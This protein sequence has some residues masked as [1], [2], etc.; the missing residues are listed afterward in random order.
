[1]TAQPGPRLVVPAYFHPAVRPQDWMTLA[2]WG[3]AVWFVVLNLADGPGPAHDP[4][5]DGPLAAIRAAGSAVACYVDTGFGR[6][7]VGDVAADLARCRDRYPADTAVFFDRVSATG[8]DLGHYA[9]L[10]ERARTVGMGTIVFNHGVHPDPRYARYA[11]L[12]GTFEGG[13]EQYRRLVVPRWARQ[14]DS[15]SVL[16][17]VHSVPQRRLAQARALVGQ[18]G[19]GAAFVTDAATGE[20]RGPNPWRRLPADRPW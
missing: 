5:F 9:G 19:V 16:H 3:A 13:W 12:L 4:A 8:D 17:L 7:S 14:R 18:H 10:A 1:M 20:L 15:A 11:D 2:G 6:R